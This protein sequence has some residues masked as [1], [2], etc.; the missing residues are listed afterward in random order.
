M[1]PKPIWRGYSQCVSFE[2]IIAHLQFCEDITGKLSS[3]VV[4][5]D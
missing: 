5:T 4:F 3:L 2:E 1:E